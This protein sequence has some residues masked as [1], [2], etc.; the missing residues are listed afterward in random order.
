NN[1]EEELDNEIKP[2]EEEAKRLINED[3]SFYNLKWDN[4]AAGGQ[5]PYYSGGSKRTQQRKNKELR[6]AAQGSISLDNFF[7]L[8]TKLDIKYEMS[9]SNTSDLDITNDNSISKQLNKLNNTL[10]NMKHMNAYEYLRHLAVHKYLTKIFDYEKPQSHIEL[11]LEISQQIFQRGPWMARR[12]LSGQKYIS[13]LIDDEDIQSSC[14]CF[15]RTIGDRITAEKFQIYVKNN[16]LPHTTGSRT[17]ISL[18]TARTWLC[19]LGLVYQSHQQGSMIF[20]E[21]LPLDDPN[22]VFRNQPKGIRQVLLERNLWPTSGLKLK[23]E[24]NYYDSN[25]PNCCAHH[26]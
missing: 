19:H 20:P 3:N 4:N 10:N 16:I 26:L 9:D 21:D 17:S 8:K 13:T 12:I 1:N 6:K 7:K 14:L 25:T 5:L 2:N 24:N 23:C 22:Y 11:S 18:E 15:I